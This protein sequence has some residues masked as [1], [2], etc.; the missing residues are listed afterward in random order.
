[1]S[2][3]PGSSKLQDIALRRLHSQGLVYA[4][5]RSPAEVLARM[6]PIQGQDYLG[7]KWSL[8]LRLADGTDAAV[9]RALDER[10][11]VRSWVLRGTL[12]LVAAADLG[13]L[14]RLVAPRLIAGNA[15]RYRELELD[16]ATLR[17]GNDLLAE[18]L[19]EAGQ[20]DRRQLL[21]M[22]ERNGISTAGQRGVYLLQRASLDGLICQ[23]AARRNV[24]IFISTDGLPPGDMDREQALAELA[25]RY[26]ASRG[27]ATIRDFTWWSGLAAAEARDALE[28]VKSELAE[29]TVDGQVYW[30]GDTNPAATK[31]PGRAWLLPGFDEYLLAYTDRRASLDSPTY[32]RPIPLGGMLPQAIVFDGHAV[33]TWKRRL[34]KT[35]VVISP[36]PFQPLSAAERRALVEAAGH[37][38][39]FLGL[40]AEL[41]K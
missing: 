4:G 22:L 20:L 31:A 30:S 13:W 10:T 37:Y 29:E 8:G 24:P 36:Q 16:E 17:R 11:I 18:A 7:A 15:R 38:A 25:R 39:K 23:T 34:K 27:P 19:R 26:F 32:H 2:A 35:S 21:S 41:G 6:G 1:M 3:K 28:A 14:L 12:H 5:F 33:G 40:S 9:E